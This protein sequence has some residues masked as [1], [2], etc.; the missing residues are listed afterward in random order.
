MLSLHENANTLLSLLEAASW[1]VLVVKTEGLER[2]DCRVD[3]MPFFQALRHLFLLCRCRRVTRVGHD[4]L[5]IGTRVRLL[6]SLLVFR[7]SLCRVFFFASFFLLLAWFLFQ[8]GL[9]GAFLFGLVILSFSCHTRV[10]L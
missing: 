4:Q 10:F 1:G 5:Q 3:N 2:V 7:N 6:Y 8:F 9:I